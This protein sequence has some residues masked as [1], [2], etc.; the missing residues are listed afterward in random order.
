M[1]ARS[2]TALTW[3][4]V[5]EYAQRTGYNDRTIRKWCAQ[6]RLSC[7]RSTR[8]DTDVEIWLVALDGTPA[9]ARRQGAPL[10]NQNRKVAK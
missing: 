8:D 2:R 4:T 3:E 1:E 9:P 6:G 10:G 5:Q 7:K